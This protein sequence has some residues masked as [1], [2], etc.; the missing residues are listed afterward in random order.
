MIKCVT[1]RRCKIFTFLLEVCVPYHFDFYTVDLQG[2]V[3][4]SHLLC[5][6]QA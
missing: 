1:L 5:D 2:C 3:M 4:S 6:A